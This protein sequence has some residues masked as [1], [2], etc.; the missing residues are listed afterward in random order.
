MILV[1]INYFQ[2]ILG[3]LTI[4]MVVPGVNISYVEICPQ[5]IG[6]FVLIGWLCVFYAGHH[7]SQRLLDEEFD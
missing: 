2:I 7:I 4:E 3:Y 6:V 1:L 5:V